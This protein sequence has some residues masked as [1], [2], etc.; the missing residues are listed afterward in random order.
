MSAF[1]PLVSIIIPAYNCAPYLPSAVESALGQTY[2]R[3]EVVVVNDG[4]PDD[5]DTVIKPYL[6][7]IQ[8]IKQENRGLSAARNAGFHASHGD[9]ICFLDADDILLPEKL[10]KQLAVFN[11][12]PDLGVVICG[13]FD[14]EADGETVIQSIR[15]EWHR[16]AI[17]KLLNHEVF[18]PHAAL[19]RRKVLNQF[20][21]FPEDIDTYESQEDWQL[22]LQLAL[23][24]VAFS[25]VPEP[26]CK[27]RRRP[28]S[29]SANPLKHLDGARRVV[30]WLRQHPNDGPYHERIERLAAIVEMERVARARLAGE[31]VLMRD[32]LTAAVK[33]WP[34]FWLEPFTYVRLL[35][36]TLPLIEENTWITTHNIEIFKHYVLEQILLSCRDGLPSS[37]FNR[38]MAAAWL[39]ASDMAY[40]SGCTITCL[41]SITLAIYTNPRVA[42]SATGWR[43]TIRGV[44]G[45]RMV[46]LLRSTLKLRVTAI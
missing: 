18:P 8:Y 17:D 14:V 23:N 9:F 6:E 25:S 29:I 45:K 12:E 20:G 24:G 15:K 4:S 43:S 2:S 11:H 32:T 35:E 40:E 31:T 33:Q 42:L 22:W 28:G 21:L 46:S 38:M 5:T 13:Y 39:A 37:V 26:L 34:S 16:N 19:I 7:R 1:E 3:V 41:H 44:L 27:Y 36:R 30:S 10:G